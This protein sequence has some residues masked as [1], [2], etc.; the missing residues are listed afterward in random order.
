MINDFTEMPVWQKAMNAAEKC[1]YI[2]ENLPKKEDYALTSQ[3]RR[4][5]SIYLLIFIKESII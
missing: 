4:S 5:E 2:S 3:L 1:F